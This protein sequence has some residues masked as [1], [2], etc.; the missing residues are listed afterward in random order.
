MQSVAVAV[1]RC[2]RPYSFQGVC[3]KQLLIPCA[4]Y[5]FQALPGR[6][7]FSFILFLLVLWPF[8][9]FCGLL[10]LG[11][12]SSVHRHVRPLLFPVSH[13]L[14]FFARSADNLLLRPF[15][16]SLGYVSVSAPVVLFSHM[17]SPPRASIGLELAFT[18]TCRTSFFGAVRLPP[19][20]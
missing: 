14:V 4:R 3:R 15:W 2:L 16:P 11:H 6:R 1:K 20:R 19:S 7:L 12:Q 10:F 17:S 13:F 5:G 8:F 18:Q 9:P